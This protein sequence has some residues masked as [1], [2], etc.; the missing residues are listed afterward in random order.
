MYVLVGVVP[1]PCVF[2]NVCGD[3][4]G[5][6]LLRC[7]LD[8]CWLMWCHHLMLS[9]IYLLVGVLPP[10]CVDR[11]ACAGWSGVTLLCCPLC[12]CRLV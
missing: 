9:A 7:P 6:T 8:M 4:F 1:P 10:T 2:R 12:M 3:W 5:D 11:Y